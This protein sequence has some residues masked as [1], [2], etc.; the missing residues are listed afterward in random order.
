MI[1]YRGYIA[2]VAI[3]FVIF[4]ITLIISKITSYKL[5]AIIIKPLAD[6]DKMM[7]DLAN[8]NIEEAIRTE[9]K[10]K[11]PISEVEELAKSTNIIMANMNNYVDTLANQ[12]IE[13]EV[14]NATLNENSRELENIN[15]DLDSKNS[16]LKNILNNVEQGF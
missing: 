2:L 13:L 9:I 3:C 6:L 7:K 4:L 1:I 15:Q 16:K 12:N 5:S 10:F 11:K 8:G 14:Q